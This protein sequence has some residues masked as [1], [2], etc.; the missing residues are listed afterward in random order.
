MKTKKNKTKRNKKK[1]AIVAS[2]TV[3]LAQLNSLLENNFQGEKTITISFLVKNGLVY[4][5]Y[6]KKDDDISGNNTIFAQA[7]CKYQEI[8]GSSSGEKDPSKA[9][10]FVVCNNVR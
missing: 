10:D 8:E 3:K 1:V 7:D 6:N 9:S 4:A 5:H 2:L